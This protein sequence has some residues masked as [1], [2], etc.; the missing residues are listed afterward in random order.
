[1]SIFNCHKCNL[2]RSRKQVV[3]GR[4]SSNPKILFIGEAPGATEDKQGTPFCG[5]SGQVL[6]QLIEEAKIEPIDC[7]I[8][9]LVKCRPPKNRNPKLEE[10]KACSPYLEKEIRMFRPI[11]IVPLGKFSSEY[12]YKKYNIPF[13]TISKEQGQVQKTGQSF[14]P[15][16]VMASFHPAAALYTPVNRKKI[17]LGFRKLNK[18]IKEK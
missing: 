1:M 11:I 7:H 13:T 16:Y 2:W 6:E 8:T 4:G 9:N 18:I 10:I 14:N 12:I 17:L 5:K 15:L 3:V